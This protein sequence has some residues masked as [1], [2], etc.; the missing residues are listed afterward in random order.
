[1]AASDKRDLSGRIARVVASGFGSGFAPVAPGTAGSFVA[2]CLG[3][4]LLKLSP[5]GL[6]L[7][8]LATSL[9]GLWAVGRAG[10]GGDPGWVVIDEFAGQFIAM[11]PLSAPTPLGL[12]A[13]FALFRLFDI[14]KPGPI[15]WADRQQGAAGVM[16]DDLI[17]GGCAALLIWAFGTFWP[18]LTGPA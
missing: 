16:A 6:P 7:A 3:A 13:A 5:A 18:G 14:T 15:G 12:L 10:G 2:L 8:I 4:V 11:L 9:G 17:A 1:M